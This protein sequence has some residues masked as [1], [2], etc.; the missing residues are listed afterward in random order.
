MVIFPRGE[1][2]ISPHASI[3]R[4]EGLIVRNREAVFFG[5][6]IQRDRVDFGGFGRV[7]SLTGWICA[8]RRDAK[9]GMPSSIPSPPPA[10]QSRKPCR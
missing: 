6:W 5:L 8:R 3:M 4:R 7:E 2:L 10:R 1:A 9:G